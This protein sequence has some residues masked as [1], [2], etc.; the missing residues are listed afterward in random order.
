MSPL[1][2][3]DENLPSDGSNVGVG[4][5]E[6]RTIWASLA[7]GLNESLEWDGVTAGQLNYFK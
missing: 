2:N 5:A 7:A 6:V 1:L 4:A 3:W